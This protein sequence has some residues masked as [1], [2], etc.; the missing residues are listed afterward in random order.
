VLLA[1]FEETVGD[2][3]MYK[4]HDYG[5]PEKTAAIGLPIGVMLLSV[6]AIVL[7]L[8]IGGEILDDHSGAVAV[9]LPQV[10]AR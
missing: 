9:Y 4:R 1:R 5:E 3:R 2:I 7:Y 8:I 6:M 10:E